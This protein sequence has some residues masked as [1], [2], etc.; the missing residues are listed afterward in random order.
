MRYIDID[1]LRDIMGQQEFD[2]WVAKAEG[3]L[4]AIRTLNKKARAKYFDAHNIWTEL[5]TYLSE[6]SHHK[7]WYSEA[8]ENSGEWE[9]EHFRPKSLSKDID[10]TIIKGDGYWWLAY[11]WRNYRLAGSLVNKRRKDRFENEDDVYGKGCFFPLNSDAGDVA[12][13]NDMECRC[14]VPLLLD[15]TNTRDVTL[16]SFDKNGEVFPTVGED[17]D[18]WAYR[19]ADISIKYYGLKHTPL[20]RGRKKIWEKCESIVYTTHKRLQNLTTDR[21]NNLFKQQCIEDCYCNL[22]KISRTTEPYSMVVKSYVEE[23]IQNP[24][25]FWL[26]HVTRVLQ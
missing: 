16:L 17:E 25:Y 7:C 20:N 12:Q 14:E 13:E 10:G 15:P 24:E 11:H 3:H 5:Y 4:N 26:R 21:I 8:P 23:K 9:I 18:E 2:A 6:L 19:R 1:R 22:E